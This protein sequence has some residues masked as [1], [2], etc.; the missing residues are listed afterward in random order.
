MTGIAISKFIRRKTLQSQ[1]NNGDKHQIAG[2]I[3]F[4]FCAIF[5][6]ASSLRNQD[7]LTLL[8]SIIFLVACAVFLVPLIRSYKNETG[9]TN[10]V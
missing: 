7:I 6:L 3:L 4:I 10:R 9:K 2:W 1:D 5:F 8:G